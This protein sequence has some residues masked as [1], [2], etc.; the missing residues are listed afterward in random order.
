MVIAVDEMLPNSDFVWFGQNGIEKVS[1]SRFVG[2]KKVVIFGVPG[3]FTPTCHSAHVPSFIRTKN[4]F[5]KKGIDTI[6]CI[7]VNDP[8]VLKAW[9]EVTGATEAGIIMLGDAEAKFTTMLGM[10]F[11]APGVGLINRSKRY[12]LFAINGKIIIFNEEQSRGECI[13][14]AGEVLLRSIKEL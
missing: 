7:S 3:A 6:I 2:S 14:S 1:L 8:H 9:G 5:K 10:D 12:S 13:T 11:N 4:D